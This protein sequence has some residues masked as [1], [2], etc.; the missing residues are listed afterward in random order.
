MQSR[1]VYRSLPLPT[2]VPRQAQRLQ[3]P[4]AVLHAQTPSSSGSYDSEGDEFLREFQQY[5]D[6]NRLQKIT[7]RLELT[8]S[9]DRVRAVCRQFKC[10]AVCLLDV[11]FNTLLM[12]RCRGASLHLVTAVMGQVK[13]NARGAEAQVW[14]LHADWY[15]A[16]NLSAAKWYYF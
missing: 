5:A 15:Y 2:R 12:L 3:Q 9:V 1:T 16:K 6:P 13:K 7:K 4:P 8:W 10:C 14:N 11:C